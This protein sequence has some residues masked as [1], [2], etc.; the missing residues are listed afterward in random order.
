MTF[1]TARR[2]RCQFEISQ[3]AL[4]ERMNEGETGPPWAQQHVAVLETHLDRTT[5]PEEWRV[6]LRELIAE[7]ETK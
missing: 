2:L 5:V 1:T 3:A 6:A 4:A 7:R